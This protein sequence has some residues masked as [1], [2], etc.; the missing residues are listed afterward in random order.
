MKNT[1]VYTDETYGWVNSKDTEFLNIEEG[2]D[3]DIMTFEYMEN[4]YS[5]KVVIG[6]KPGK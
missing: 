3:G 2:F 4:E 1:W 5:S 6:S